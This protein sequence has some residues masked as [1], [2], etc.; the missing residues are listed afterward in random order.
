M[1]EPR[2]ESSPALTRGGRNQPCTKSRNHWQKCHG[3]K[4]DGSKFSSSASSPKMACLVPCVPLV[5]FHLDSFYG[6]WISTLRQSAVR[7]SE[8]F[9][10]DEILTCSAR[11]LQFPEVRWNTIIKWNKGKKPKLGHLKVNVHTYI[12]ACSLKMRMGQP[13]FEDT[14]ND[15][16]IMNLSHGNNQGPKITKKWKNGTVRYNKCP[17][18]IGCYQKLKPSGLMSYVRMLAWAREIPL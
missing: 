9:L 17:E 7:S 11:P 8:T 15:K 2:S 5:S 13:Y 4:E 1:T 10:K 3:S 12:Y 6:T 18:G 16:V 14:S